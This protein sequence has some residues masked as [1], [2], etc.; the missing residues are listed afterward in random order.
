MKRLKVHENIFPSLKCIHRFSY[1][2]NN[3][4]EYNTYIYIIWVHVEARWGV[5]GI[6]RIH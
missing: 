3:K 4:D 6:F 2:Y 1:I 5:N